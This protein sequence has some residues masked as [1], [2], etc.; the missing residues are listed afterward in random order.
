MSEQPKEKTRGQ[1][2]AEKLMSV[3][4][5]LGG[6]SYLS[7]SGDP[8]AHFQI[9]PPDGWEDAL[10]GAAETVASLIDAACDE[11]VTEAFEAVTEKVNRQCDALEGTFRR[12]FASGLLIQWIKFSDE[13]YHMDRRI[14]QALKVADKFIAALAAPK[15]A[16]AIYHAS[17]GKGSILCG[18]G[19]VL[20]MAD[21]PAT[22]SC[23]KCLALMGGGK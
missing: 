21:S 11:A 3:S 1:R 5:N 17:R 23:P 10:T 6:S 16:V 4:D 7:F 13:E 18:A 8:G 20:F 2:I 15:E 19:G 22:V 14:E 12:D 9:D